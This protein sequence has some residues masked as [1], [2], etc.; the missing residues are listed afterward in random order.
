[1]IAELVPFDQTRVALDLI[2]RGRQMGIAEALNKVPRDIALRLV[3]FGYSVEFASEACDV[4][5]EDLRQS[6]PDPS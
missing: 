4:P 5:V 3:A 2:E 1:M 6:L